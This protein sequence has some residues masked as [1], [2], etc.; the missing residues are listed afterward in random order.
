VEGLS[1]AG[2]ESL[3]SAAAGLTLEQLPPA[4]GLSGADTSRS[5]MSTTRSAYGR[6]DPSKR[7]AGAL[8]VDQ[9]EVLIAL[10]FDDFM[11]S[12]MKSLD[13][14]RVVRNAVT[15]QSDPDV[16]GVL[17]A[18]PVAVD[19]CWIP[20][21]AWIT[22]MCFAFSSTE[23]QLT[24]RSYPEHDITP[25]AMTMLVDRGSEKRT[26]IKSRRPL[27]PKDAPPSDAHSGAADATSS[28]SATGASS[29]PASAA[30]P[31]SGGENQPA[32]RSE[33]KKGGGKGKPRRSSPAKQSPKT[34]AALLA[35]PR[36]KPTG[37]KQKV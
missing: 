35:D 6:K 16:C 22:D 33:R 11:A 8:G 5:G 9:E 30:P 17:H 3:S 19:E 31:A 26:G 15:I 12:G 10:M 25:P 2:M 27:R 21:D 32:A 20:E 23:A 4:A 18:T 29:R 1:S 14:D 28:Q 24:A 37:S 34:N 7:V 36:P 13:Y